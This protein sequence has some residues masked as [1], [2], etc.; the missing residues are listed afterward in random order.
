MVSRVYVEKKPGFDGEARAL[1]AELRDIVGIS[2]LTGVRL[3]NRYDVE[4]AT[5]ELFAACVPTVFSEPQSD[6]ATFELPEANGAAVFAVEFLPGQ[7]DQRADSASECIQL[8]SQ[9]ERP[10]VRSAVVYYLEGD[11]TEDDVEAVKRYVINPVEAREASLDT[12]DTLAMAFER[13]ADVEVIEGFTTFADDELAR[14]IDER[15]LAMDLAD[16]QFCRAYFAEEGRDPSITEIKMID[17]YWSDH[18]RHTTFGTVLNEVEIAD[19]NVQ[20]AFDRYLELRR[21]LGRDE[22]PVCLMDMG[23]IGAKWLKKEGI[24]TGL[25]ESEEI[26]ACTIKCKVDV[27]GEE[28]DWLYLFKNETHNHPTEIEP[29]GGAATC[30]GGAPTCTRPC[31]SRARPIP[32]CPWPTPFPANCPSV[33]WSLRRQPAIPPTATRSAW[34]RARCT[35]CTTPVTPPS[36]W[37]SARWWVPRRPTTCVARP[38][39]RAMW[40]CFSA[41]ARA[42]TASA[43]PR[44]LP[45]PIPW[46]RWKAAGPRCRRVTRPWSARSSACSAAATRA[47]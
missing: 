11:L 12:R 8:I 35:S 17:T 26:N 30:V 43:A 29:F 45:R 16:I 34:P 24:L 28:Q 41:A 3:V 22:K 15:G 7:F 37:K 5:D 20:A 14:F 42:A 46:S 32:R 13:P 23:T 9:G 36:A 27:D 39:R 47:A 18:C 10:A 6:T 33:S 44:A 40:W 1:A 21:E 38:R 2:G 4:G 31:A 19:A 25:D